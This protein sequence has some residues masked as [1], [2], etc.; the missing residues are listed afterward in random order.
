MSR[1][2][3]LISAFLVFHLASIT[4]AALPP[5]GH[6][7]ASALLD[8]VSA[9]Y[10]QT[11]SLNQDWRM[12][13]NPALDA[14]YVRI[15]FWVDASAAGAGGPTAVRAVDL[16]VLPEITPGRVRDDFESFRASFRDRAVDRALDLFAAG[17]EESRLVD[18]GNLRISLW[19]RSDRPNPLTPVTRYFRRLFIVHSLAP[20]E[21]VVRTEL[22]FGHGS[23]RLPERQPESAAAVPLSPR[24][25]G[26]LE[27]QGGI[28]WTLYFVDKT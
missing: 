8:G 17:Y 25:P 12:F 11:F 1:S 9:A 28:H 6:S 4:K 18:P 19:T 10:V 16:R 14:E 21:H 24:E 20:N 2:E 22:W 5:L 26:A 27:D 13:V 7:A 15:V 3:R 23:G